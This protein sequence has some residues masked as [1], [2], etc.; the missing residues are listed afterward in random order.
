MFAEDWCFS[1]SLSFVA[2]I[3][4]QELSKVALI[5][6]QKMSI[7]ALI[8]LQLLLNINCSFV[9]ID[10]FSTLSPLRRCS[11]PVELG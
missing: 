2:L 5:L 9:N 7:I 1:D 11:E 8:P 10:L 4:L 6:L 3:S